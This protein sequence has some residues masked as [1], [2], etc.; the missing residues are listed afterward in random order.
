MA[1]AATDDVA[2]VACFDGFEVYLVDLRT[3]AVRAVVPGVPYPAGV[4]ILPGGTRA[5]VASVLGGG[6]R[7]LDL[8]T[9]AVAV[10]IPAF[11]YE[12]L[13][14]HITSPPLRLY[15]RYQPLVASVTGDTLFAAAQEPSPAVVLFDAATGA[16]L[17]AIPT[18]VTPRTFAL[19]ADGR[20]LVVGEFLHDRAF[21]AIEVAT[22]TAGP[23]RPLPPG[24]VALVS[25][26]A[27]SADGTEALLGLRRPD[28]TGPTAALV[29]LDGSAPT[30]I[31]TRSFEFGSAASPDG[32]LALGV[33][34]DGAGAYDFA[35]GALR[36]LTPG[37]W[38]VAAGFSPWGARWGGVPINHPG[39]VVSLFDATGEPLFRL[40][41]LPGG[42]LEGDAPAA[43]DVGPG[44]AEALVANVYTDAVTRVDLASKAVTGVVPL[45]NVSAVRIAALWDDLALVSGADST[46]AALTTALFD[47][48]EGA[49][50]GR[51]PG[52]SMRRFARGVAPTVFAW[53]DAHALVR[54]RATAAALDVVETSEDSLIGAW[55]ASR[56]GRL[57]AVADTAA[58][59]VLFYGGA[60]GAL[61]GTAGVPGLTRVAVAPGGQRAFAASAADALIRR[62]AFDG[63]AVVEDGTIACGCGTPALLATN[64]ALVAVLSGQTVYRFDAATGDPAGVV[65]IPYGEVSHLYLTDAG[66]VVAL[67]EDPD[68][69]HLAGYRYGL[70]GRPTDFA[71]APDFGLAL[72]VDKGDD[73]LVVG[74]VRLVATEAGPEA[75][76]L[77][78]RVSPNPARGPLRVEYT[79]AGAPAAAR[80]AVY[81]LLGRLVYRTETP[82]RGPGRH[83]LTVDPEAAP[84]PS[85][86]YVVRLRVGGETA[87]A[88][89]TVVR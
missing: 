55:A 7:I 50:V 64:E 47:L 69:V 15:Y 59:R 89:A 65:V 32:R 18:T 26:F 6:A 8:A 57:L 14:L 20:T 42:P 13:E 4:R 34:V 88:R 17:R 16:L 11:P 63:A 70:D 43:V 46:G 71:F 40:D 72:A 52:V 39:E 3:Y 51:L 37:R 9:G 33:G 80:L 31:P 12:G 62:Y 1:V 79:W 19:S 54:L 24:F 86:V 5:L 22:A 53:S 27:L 66:E 68:V 21:Q 44:G 58:D 36:V 84:L 10:T 61:L 45:A 78:L 35:T 41:A 82:P 28:G 74:D 75:G 73:A 76:A 30:L 38:Y 81:D 77:G 60:T 25:D 87:Q 49:E 85:G 23:P 83:T 67:T 56:D 48:A 29:P 2:V